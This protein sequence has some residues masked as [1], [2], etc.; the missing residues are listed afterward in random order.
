MYVHVCPVAD[1]MVI[2]KLYKRTLHNTA[3]DGFSFVYKRCK[4]NINLF[5]PYAVAWLFIDDMNSYDVILQT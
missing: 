5:S 1:N 2:R 4:F 3:D